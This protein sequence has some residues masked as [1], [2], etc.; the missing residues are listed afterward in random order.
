RS[1]QNGSWFSPPVAKEQVSLVKKESGKTEVKTL[2]TQQYMSQYFLPFF[3][4]PLFTLK[5]GAIV[6][7]ILFVIFIITG[8]SNAVNLTD[9]LDG[10]AAGCL[11]MVSGV[12]A[13]FAFL[14]N[15]IEMAR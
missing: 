2:S 6:L 15:N 11:V 14:S 7:G 10:L 4:D 9:G 5:G 8:S 13:L 3:K 1:V 12:L